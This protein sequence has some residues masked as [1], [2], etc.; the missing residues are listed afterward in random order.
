MRTESWRVVGAFQLIGEVFDE[1]SH[2]E[3]VWNACALTKARWRSW[4]DDYM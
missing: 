1:L 4:N 3:E 2:A